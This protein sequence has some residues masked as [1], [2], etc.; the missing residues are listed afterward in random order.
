MPN[1]QDDQ[2]HKPDQQQ[3][4]PRELSGEQTPPKRE[5]V[6]ELAAERK[7]LELLQANTKDQAEAVASEALAVVLAMGWTFGAKINEQG[8]PEFCIA[9]LPLEM[10]QDVNREILRNKLMGK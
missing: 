5:P 3:V 9:P 10:W 7:R 2:E 4:D 8:V 6:D 1:P